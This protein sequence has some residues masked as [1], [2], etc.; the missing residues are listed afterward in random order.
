MRVEIPRL[1]VLTRSASKGRYRSG[2]AWCPMCDSRSQ[3]A[4]IGKKSHQSVHPASASRA[5]SH[6]QTC[7]STS[8]ASAAHARTMRD[9]T[10]QSRPRLC[11]FSLPTQSLHLPLPHPPPRHT[12]SHFHSHSRSHPHPH[13]YPHHTH[14]PTS[15]LHCLFSSPSPSP[16]VSC[17][18]VGDSHRRSFC[19]PGRPPNHLSYTHLLS[20]EPSGTAHHLSPSDVTPVLHLAT[21]YCYYYYYHDHHHNHHNHHHHQHQ[22]YYYPELPNPH[23]SR[24]GRTSATTALLSLLLLSL[25]LL[26]LRAIHVA[27]P[28]VSY[29]D[30]TDR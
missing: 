16:S 19:G 6:A 10:G 15:R 29:H 9:W 2:R 5:R 30:C 28:I 3:S 26:R 7:T 11:F 8:Q 17:D 4:Q 18:V 1:S 21:Y 24:R 12:H 25:L 27:L 22:H 20:P 13:T 14:T 23:S